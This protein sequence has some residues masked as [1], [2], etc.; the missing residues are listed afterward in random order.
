MFMDVWWL[1][2]VWLVIDESH[3]ALASPSAAAFGESVNQSGEV[4]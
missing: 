3:R 4:V 1:V 2:L